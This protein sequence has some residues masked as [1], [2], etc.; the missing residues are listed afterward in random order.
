MGFTLRTVV[1]EK[2][3]KVGVVI[4]R[5]P[6]P[7]IIGVPVIVR[8][9]EHELCRYERAGRGTAASEALLCVTDS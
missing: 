3:G 7:A 2:S 4:E 9:F 1:R 8:A 5:R 6:R